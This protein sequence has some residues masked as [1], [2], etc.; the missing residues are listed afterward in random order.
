[1]SEKLFWN[2]I[3]LSGRNCDNINKIRSNIKKTNPEII[4]LLDNSYSKYH[5]LIW[6]KLEPILGDY[7]DEDSSGFK[8][9]VFYLLS[10]G[11]DRLNKFLSKDYNRNYF[12][13]MSKFN[14]EYKIEDK[15]YNYRSPYQLIEVY[16]TKEFGNMLVIDNDVQLTELDEKNYHEMIVHVPINY[17][18]DK[19]NVLIVGGGDG[20]T[21]REVIKHNNVEKATIVELDENVINTSIKYLPKVS[22]GAFN[23]SKVNKIIGD[24]FKYVKEYNGP[25]ID[26]VIIDSTDFNQS[27]SLH[28][29]EFFMNLKKILNEKHIVC[30][31]GDNV[32]WNENN[33]VS[34]VNGRKKIFKYVNLYTVYT[35]TFAGG[36]YS[37][38]LCSDSINPLNFN[39][40]W[41]LFEDKNLNLQYYTPDIH[42]ASFALPRKLKN[43]LTDD[44]SSTG[45]HYIL[46]INNVS[47]DILDNEKKLD[48]IFIDAINVSN[49][50]LLTKNTYKFKPQGVTGLYMLS[51]S[52]A[53]FHTYPENNRVFIDLFSCG[54]KKDTKNGIEYIIKKFAEYP[55]NGK[56]DYKLTQ[57]N[58]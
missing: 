54:S 18:T 45:I 2:I 21:L 20:G 15:L 6:A 24:G 47:F 55:N 46:D 23:H 49:M 56:I 27:F 25:K 9:F 1:M 35:P 28:T 10:K 16:K 36:F 30:F 41:Q 50:K 19:I 39:I 12:K 42:L 17:F 48:Q 31:N 40:D 44:V 13:D 32:N 7:Y 29:D 38:C 34:M 57:V 52:H 22:D 8:N 53:S 58:R 37:F 11:E 26:L 43:R 3:K 33:I 5:Y 14:V 51:T 4:Q